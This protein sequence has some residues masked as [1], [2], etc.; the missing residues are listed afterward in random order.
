MKQSHDI[1]PL[2]TFLS[3]GSP[4]L[5]P[6]HPKPPSPMNP[7]H[8]PTHT[9]THTHHEQLLSSFLPSWALLPQGRR[10]SIRKGSCP[11][12]L[13]LN[14]GIP[15]ALRC[16]ILPQPS[17]AP[18]W[19]EGGGKGG[20]RHMHAHV[21]SW[22]E[23][24]R[25]AYARTYDQQRERLTAW[26]RS[27]THTHTKE[28]ITNGP[29]P[30]PPP[31]PTHTCLSV[32]E[33]RDSLI[34]CAHQQSPALPPT[35]ARLF[36]APTPQLGQPQESCYDM[37]TLHWC[38]WTHI[39]FQICFMWKRGG[40]VEACKHPCMD[41]MRMS[42]N[43]ILSIHCIHLCLPTQ[44]KGYASPSSSP[45]SSSQPPPCPC[46]SSSCAMV[47]TASSAL[48]LRSAASLQWDQVWGCR[49]VQDDLRK[50]YLLIIWCYVLRTG[51]GF[52]KLF[53]K[54][55]SSHACECM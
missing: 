5:P 44:S 34:C 36:P 1:L 20:G 33:W 2:H 13:R 47:V 12:K 31:L 10:P 39:Y 37:T 40:R 49:A 28:I 30:F 6:S 7:T 21:S 27:H 15:V 52:S 25:W 11:V 17:P 24:G 43:L 55:P 3:L 38:V 50:K 9:R 35:T 18:A 54:G 32:C 51:R 29:A 19:G 48:V 41:A 53:E 16:S 8:A 42:T 14:G 46:F 45:P 22:R 4:V 23:R 26:Q